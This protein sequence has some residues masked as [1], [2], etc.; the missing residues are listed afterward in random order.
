VHDL[1][2]R[3]DARW[4]TEPGRASTGILGSSLGGL[5]SF[6][7]GLRY[8][9]VFRYVGGMSS[10]FD[11]GKIGLTNPTVLDLYSGTADLG[12]HDQ[13]YYLDSGG[14]PPASGPCVNPGD[15]SD[16]YC[17]TTAMVAILGMKG[18]QTF[19]LDPNAVPLMPA[20]IDIY[21]WWEPNAQHNE[22]SWHARVHRPLRLFF[23]P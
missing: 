22:T 19:P 15:G 5:I 16:N 9:D 1:K 13:V 17:S 6:Y 3:I 14:G 11:W 18:I 23:R 10:T 20:N 12:T 4:R 7:L 8:P 21:H 2:P